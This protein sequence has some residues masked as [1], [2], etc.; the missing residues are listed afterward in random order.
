MFSFSLLK[1]DP[2][3]AT[4]LKGIYYLALKAKK[5]SYFT[6]ICEIRRK[7]NSSEH[8]ISGLLKLSDGI[9]QSINLYANKN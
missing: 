7:D 4:Y 1:D 6:L 5:E 2:Q 3:N 9:Q 8:T